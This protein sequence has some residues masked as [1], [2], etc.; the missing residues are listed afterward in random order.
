MNEPSEFDAQSEQS[1]A[2]QSWG[3]D[4][5]WDSLIK[6][7]RDGDEDACADFWKQ[8]GSLLEGVASK[9]LSER[10]QRRVGS[11]DVVQSACRT[12][13]RRVG[14]GQFELPDADALW[15]LMCAITLTKARRAGRDHSRQKR[16]MSQEQYIDAQAGGDDDRK[17]DIEG[18]QETPL[19]AVLVSDQIQTL[20]GNLSEQ[21]CQIFDLKLQNFTN[22]EIADQLKCSE[23]TVRRLTSQIRD[24]WNT[25]FDESTI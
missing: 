22:D 8:Y 12:F 25:L 14:E 4:Q 2:E 17:F 7:L 9:Q 11:D 5:E 21:E 10:L 15:R 3:S 1:R 18:R 6:G 19:N 13:F 23:R 20:L 24:R 16:G